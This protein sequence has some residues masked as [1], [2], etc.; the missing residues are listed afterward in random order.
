MAGAILAYLLQLRY[1][2]PMMSNHTHFNLL[3][4]CLILPTLDVIRAI[5]IEAAALPGGAGALEALQSI[6]NMP[7]ELKLQQQLLEKEREIWG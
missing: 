7:V 5:A 2:L 4:S 6:D 1:N 3:L